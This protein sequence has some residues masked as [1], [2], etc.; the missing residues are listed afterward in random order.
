M[1]GK[2]FYLN[3][4]NINLPAIKNPVDCKTGLRASLSE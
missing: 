4:E 2:Y 1:K 3:A